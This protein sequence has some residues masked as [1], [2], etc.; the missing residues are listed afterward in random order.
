MD[1]EA[2]CVS[3]PQFPQMLACPGEGM[4][5]GLVACLQRVKEAHVR[6]LEGLEEGRI[7]PSS[8]FED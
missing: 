8:C 6:A 2:L 1:W 3:G 7:F 4:H 5:L